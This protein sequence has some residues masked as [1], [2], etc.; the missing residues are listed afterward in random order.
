MPFSELVAPAGRRL[1]RGIALALALACGG[2]VS[3]EPA[4][5]S[6]KLPPEANSFPV[7]EQMTVNGL[8]M[9]IHGF[10]LRKAPLETAEWFRKSMGKPLMENNVGNK[11]VLGRGEGSF[12][13]S[14]QLE[15]A[16]ADGKSTRGT[17]AVSDLKGAQERRHGTAAVNARL[18]GRMPFGTK[19]LNQMSSRDQGKLATYVL[20]EN[21]HSEEL[22]RN[23]LVESLRAEGLALEREARLDRQSG[24]LPEA[25]RHG[26]TLFFKGAGKEAMAV[27]RPAGA[28]KTSIVLNTVTI[29]EHVK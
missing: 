26:R 3:A 1:A 5:P 10:V 25:M 20:A 12:Y 28:G 4:W 7:G 18:L 24:A 14:V 2:A 22:N 19:L 15:S 6:V 8:P 9:R 16:G 29:M 27:I 21:G 11:L 13:V 23:R 17:V